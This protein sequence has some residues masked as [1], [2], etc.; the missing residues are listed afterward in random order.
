MIFVATPTLWTSLVYLGCSIWFW[1][2]I[3]AFWGCVKH[4]FNLKEIKSL[5]SDDDNWLSL[6]WV[7]GL[8]V[9][10]CHK[11][12]S[13]ENC[14]KLHIDHCQSFTY[15][16]KCVIFLP[17]FLLTLLTT[18][19]QYLQEGELSS[20]LLCE[21]WKCMCIQTDVFHIS[22]IYV[23]IYCEENLFNIPG[24]SSYPDSHAHSWD[25]SGA[26]NIPNI[27]HSN[28]ATL[29]IRGE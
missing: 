12:G 11:S 7:S 6:E 26:Q 10:H 15:S 25:V 18:L 5:D 16:V 27:F 17:I 14:K 1:G 29:I 8:P 23:F 24:E 20:L 21:V 19:A 22:Y 13:P 4:N 28:I 3:G 2:K 9:G